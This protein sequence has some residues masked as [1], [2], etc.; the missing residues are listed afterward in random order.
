MAIGKQR[1]KHRRNLERESER[2][3]SIWENYPSESLNL[4]VLTK[5]SLV[6]NL[7][8]VGGIGTLGCLPVFRNL[9][10]QVT[11]INHRT[12]LLLGYVDFIHFDQF[13]EVAV[14]NYKANQ[15]FIK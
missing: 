7:Q 14:S 4:S 3:L 9:L 2:D 8:L 11:T 15:F 12:A 13:F 5:I 1:P 10:I 6:Q